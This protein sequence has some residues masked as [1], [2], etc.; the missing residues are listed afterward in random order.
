[1]KPGHIYLREVFVETI[2]DAF[3]QA[4]FFDPDI[5]VSAWVELILSAPSV[6]L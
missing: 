1:M 4:F 2:K 6:P 5:M 3:Y